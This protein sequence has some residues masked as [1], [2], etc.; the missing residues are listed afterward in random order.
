[1]K[2]ATVIISAIAIVSTLAIAPTITAQA[3]SIPFIST[4]IGTIQTYLPI[5]NSIIANSNPSTVDLAASRGAVSNSSVYDNAEVDLTGEEFDPLYSDSGEISF[6]ESADDGANLKLTTAPQTLRTRTIDEFKN[7]TEFT[8]YRS[9]TRWIAKST[10][11]ANQNN[12]NATTKA[13]DIINRAASVVGSEPVGTC[14]S[15]LCAENTQNILIAQQIELQSAAMSLSIVSNSYSKIHADELGLLIRSEQDKKEAE[16]NKARLNSIN[17]GINMTNR[18]NANRLIN[19][20][21]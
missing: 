13:T 20:M 19:T 16:L 5:V 12:I 14:N 1:M 6:D 2:K 7:G 11:K 17:N 9:G 21:Y 8:T 18:I 4:L 10:Q 3:Q 15:S